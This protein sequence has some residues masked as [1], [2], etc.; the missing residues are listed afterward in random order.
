MFLPLSFVKGRKNNSIFVMAGKDEDN[1]DDDDGLGLVRLDTGGYVCVTCGKVLSNTSN[2]YRHVRETH[3]VN[4]QSQCNIC[5]RNFK[6][7]HQLTSHV[8]IV[9]ENKLLCTM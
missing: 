5:Q 1:G 6:L 8:K 9:H 2:G 3:R 4:Q 7:H